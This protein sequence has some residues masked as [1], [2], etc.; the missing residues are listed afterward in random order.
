[1]IKLHTWCMGDCTIG[2]LYYGDGQNMFQC[3]TLE[4][5]FLANAVDVSC[6]QAGVYTARKI[7]SPTAGREVLRLFGVPN[8][9]LINVEAANYTREILGCILVGDSIQFLDND[10]VP[11][12]TNSNFTLNKL[13]ALLPHETKIDITRVGFYV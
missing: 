5:P 9:S 13:L 10:S 3:F 4:L 8:R 12:V 7:Q 11:D 2:R 1:M 6:V